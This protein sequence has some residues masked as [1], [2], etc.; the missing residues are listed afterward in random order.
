MASELDGDHDSEIESY[1]IN[2]D[3]T[4]FSRLAHVYESAVVHLLA[5]RE[6][7][8]VAPATLRAFQ[9]SYASTAFR[10]RFPHSKV[11]RMTHAEPRPEEHQQD[12]PGPS[13]PPKYTKRF[14]DANRFLSANPGVIHAT[15]VKP[16]PPDVLNAQIVQNLPHDVKTWKQLKDWTQQNPS[17]TPDIDTQKL[18]LL[19]ILHFLDMVRQQ[20]IGGVE[21]T[22]IP[23]NAQETPTPQQN[24]QDQVIINQFAKKL[25]DTAKPEVIQKFETDVG[26]WPDD[27]KQQLL[28]QGINPLFFRFRQHAE[29][30]Y[31][32]GGPHKAGAVNTGAQNDILHQ[33]ASNDSSSQGLNPSA[34]SIQET[35]AMS[36]D[37]SFNNAPAE[38]DLQEQQRLLN[39]QLVL[40]ENQNKKP[41]GERWPWMA[42]K[43]NMRHGPPMQQQQRV[44]YGT[45]QTNQERKRRQETQQHRDESVVIET[46]SPVIR[47]EIDNDSGYV[48]LT[49]AQKDQM[50]QE[51][52]A[53]L[54]KQNHKRLLQKWQDEDQEQKT[55]EERWRHERLMRQQQGAQQQNEDDLASYAVPDQPGYAG[56]SQNPNTQSSPFTGWNTPHLDRSHHP[57]QLPPNLERNIP[58]H[59]EQYSKSTFEQLQSPHQPYGSAQLPKLNTTQPYYSG[60]FAPTGVMREPSPPTTQ[61]HPHHTR[62]SLES[63]EIKTAYSSLPSKY[64]FNH[65]DGPSS[66]PSPAERPPEPIWSPFN[67]RQNIAD[68]GISPNNNQLSKDNRESLPSYPDNTYATGMQS[69]DLARM[70]QDVRWYPKQ[71]DV[72][73]R[74][75]VEKEPP[76]SSGSQQQTPPPRVARQ[77]HQ[78]SDKE[79]A[80]LAPGRLV[81]DSVQSQ[82]MRPSTH[83]DTTRSTPDT[84]GIAQNMFTFGSPSPKRD[85]PHEVSGG[86][87]VGTWQPPDPAQVREELRLYGEMNQ[88]ALAQGRAYRRPT[89]QRMNR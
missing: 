84:G 86:Q 18:M 61:Q 24:R 21:G 15:D 5:Q 47:R 67:L 7:Q 36:R 73:Q 65:A 45:Q 6:V 81:V 23:S 83:R 54:E 49:Q 88:S 58:D 38:L 3:R 32:R 14:A 63:K 87:G 37:P 28:D 75:Y 78:P 13:I 8:G 26:R 69:T 52:L 80:H 53:L 82:D 50:Y 40:L 44:P 11:R 55:Q 70:Q 42:E 76:T 4:L 10:C 66:V 29:M 62:G 89:G 9:E 60:A 57:P 22:H 46:Q 79:M 85:H 77:P 31:K 39:E 27:K 64:Y 59:P 25:M 41:W 43:D 17:L 51:Q 74:P 33:V 56:V 68:R 30:I 35:G 34:A 20:K 2:N 1:V 12:S 48:V 71:N 72:V 19:Q 16:F